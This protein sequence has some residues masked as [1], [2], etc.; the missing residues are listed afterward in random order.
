MP[1]A[2]ERFLCLVDPRAQSAFFADVEPVSQ[3]ALLALPGVEL[4][5]PE[6]IDSL[7]FIRIEG[8]VIPLPS[9]LKLPFVQAVF[10]R[11]ADG[12]LGYAA[13][14][15]RPQLTEHLETGDTYRGKTNVMVTKLA[16]ALAGRVWAERTGDTA[17]TSPVVLDPM[18]GR[19]TTLLAAARMDWC[20][21]G[22]E[23]DQAAMQHLH[24]HLK[25]QCKVHR[26]KHGVSRGWTNRKNS[27][28]DGKFLEYT[29]E[30]ATIRLVAGDTR[31][32]HQYVGANRHDLL[33]VDLPYGVEFRGSRGQRSPL[34]TVQQAIESWSIALRERG[35]GCIVF[36]RLQPSRRDL[37]AVIQSAGFEV[38]D[39]ELRHRMSDAI[40]R[41]FLIFAC[42]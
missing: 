2:R 15:S 5:E 31:K 33:V 19:G 16:L 32:T 26:I 35:A 39:L 17:V 3:A 10:Q 24:R 8:D 30:N 40:E 22:I 12:H 42:K 18:C 28:G 4:A 23:Q 6:R 11:D 20:A 29:F 38:L 27:D 21:S 7:S 13:S 25:R 9:V 37:V 36:N 14:A 1:R 41:D 34:A